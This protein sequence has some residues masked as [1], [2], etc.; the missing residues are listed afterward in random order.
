LI[1]PYAED[2]PK[3]IPKRCQVEDIA[4]SGHNKI[5]LGA[6]AQRAARRYGKAW[7]RTRSLAPVAKA[8]SP[9][10]AVTEWRLN[11]PAD[12]AWTGKADHKP[13]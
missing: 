6:P 10:V 2:V 13:D 1:R 12:R 8:S 5:A 3:V 11:P 9:G 4:S 7:P